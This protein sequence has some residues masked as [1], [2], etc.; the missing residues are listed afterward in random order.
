MGGKSLLIL[1]FPN[2]CKNR[3]TKCPIR[4]LVGHTSQTAEKRQ[5]NGRKTAEKRQEKRGGQIEWVNPDP[6]QLLDSVCD[7]H[8]QSSF[9][10]RL[11][12]ETPHQ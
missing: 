5:K 11:H 2:Q 8:S 1:F 9:R 6:I 3:E 10:D 4:G 12:H 7:F